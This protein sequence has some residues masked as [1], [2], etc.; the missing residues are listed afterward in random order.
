[1]MVAVAVISIM[2]AVAVPLVLISW[3][4]SKEETAINNVEYLNQASGS[5]SMRGSRSRMLPGRLPTSVGILKRE[6]C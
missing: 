4:T 2:G 6:M 5:I 1:M 3:P